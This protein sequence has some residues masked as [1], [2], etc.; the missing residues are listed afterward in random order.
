MA[1]PNGGP[2]E[3]KPRYILLAVT[4]DGK[5]WLHKSKRNNNGTFSIGKS[6]SLTELM[7]LEV[8]SD[9]SFGITLNH[10]SYYWQTDDPGDQIEFLVTTVRCFR[11][12]TGH[13]LRIVGFEV[14]EP[15]NAAPPYS[16]PAPSGAASIPSRAPAAVP[17]Q[18][19]PAVRQSPSQNS[20]LSA[21]AAAP[22]MA[23]SSSSS[24]HSRGHSRGPSL[25]NSAPARPQFPPVVSSNGST[26]RGPSPQ[27]YASP[28]QR[29]AQPPIN[30][31]SSRNQRTPEPP[32]PR[33]LPASTESRS[34]HGSR[35]SQQMQLGP[36]PQQMLNRPVSP[37]G[38][39]SAYSSSTRTGGA[40][41][42]S[43]R[44][45]SRP[46][47]PPAPRHIRIQT[48]GSDASSGFRPDS[49]NGRK[50]SSESV[51]QAKPTL[52][53][54]TADEGAAVDEEPAQQQQQLQ[55][56]EEETPFSAA[57][58]SG[59]AR[60]LTQPEE[61]QTLANVE[62]MLEGFEWRSLSLST[63]GKDAANIVDAAGLLQNQIEKSLVDELAALEAASIHA[64]V[65]SDDRVEGVLGHLTDSM[66]E[67][68]RLDQMITLYK[69]Q[70]NIMTDDIDHIE[71][72]NK[73]L[74]VE[75]AN[76]R[77]LVAELDQLLDT[78]NIPQSDLQ[79]LARESLES[80]SGIERLE[81]AAVG[82]YKA[83]L[84]MRDKCALGL[85]FLICP[86]KLM[87]VG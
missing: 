57:M 6:W 31:P 70:L 86:Q 54:P 84:S 81:R 75:L 2:P 78:I 43:P 65:E 14:N 71:G 30:G 42:T 50:M 21:S 33:P 24:S 1:S 36:A 76:Q 19:P 66:A 83:V 22:A 5:L 18:P 79:A 46:T 60:G 28:P 68:D 51:P 69:T 27:P 41:N 62:E 53:L 8:A 87:T 10:K 12:H 49:R 85:L 7:G 40:V 11:Y 34:R 44:K 13:N 82:L 29:P 26:S 64:I 80:Q 59:L 3:S 61:D 55:Q 67:L 17:P 35:G 39:T 9:N 4:P 15:P 56:P 20:N 73:G 45:P 77:A 23:P 47:T 37:A 74:Q 63:S 25:T 16:V 48:G 32:A 72:Q 38:S 52:S 58:P